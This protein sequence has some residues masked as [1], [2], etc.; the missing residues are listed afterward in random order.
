MFRWSWME[1]SSATIVAICDTVACEPRSPKHRFQHAGCNT[2]QDLAVQCMYILIISIGHAGIFSQLIV[3]VGLVQRC[4]GEPTPIAAPR[5]KEIFGGSNDGHVSYE[6][7]A[8]AGKSSEIAFA[9]FGTPIHIAT[10]QPSIFHIAIFAA[11]IAPHDQDLIV[12]PQTITTMAFHEAVENITVTGATHAP[13]FVVVSPM[14]H[15]IGPGRPAPVLCE[16]ATKGK[17]SVHLD[18]DASLS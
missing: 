8:I 5:V 11:G 15:T 6:I 1:I 18:L 17:Q 9:Q 7:A 3:A 13:I 14:P 16:A 2:L 12:W 10:F 4:H